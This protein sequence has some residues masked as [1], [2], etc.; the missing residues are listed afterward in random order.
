MVAD[1]MLYA[2]EDKIGKVCLFRFAGDKIE[3]VSSFKVTEGNGPRI[4]Y[5]AV[6]NGMLFIRRGNT[7]FAYNIKNS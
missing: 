6:A 4:A 2:Y 5:M 7:L 1:D 3:L